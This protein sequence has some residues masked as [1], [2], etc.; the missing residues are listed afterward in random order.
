MLGLVT[1]FTYILE[2]QAAQTGFFYRLASMY[3]FDVIQREAVLAG[4]TE[5]DHILCIGGGLCPFSGILFHQITGARV[6]IIDNNIICIPTAKQVINRL[7]IGEFVTVFCQ[8]GANAELSLEE[9]SVIH[10]ALQLSHKGRVFEQAVKNATPGARLLVR[11][12]KAYLKDMYGRF[13]LLN[14]CPYTAHRAR[15]IGSTALYVV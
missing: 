12:P 4:I 5:K 2:N 15:G 13:E 8:D 1:D 3:Y 11:R 10:L 9:Y 7:G 6:T 14:G